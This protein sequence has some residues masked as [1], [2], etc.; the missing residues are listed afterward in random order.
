MD[1]KMEH[2]QQKTSWQPASEWY[3]SIVGEEGHYYHQAIIL[4]RLGRL[5]QIKGDPQASLLD[6]ACGQG[7][8]GRQVAADIDVYGFDIAPSLIK[9]ASQYDRSRRHHYA[10]AD[11]TKAL[12]LEKKDFSHAAIILALQ[13]IEHPQAA[14]SNA[15]KHLKPGGKLFLVLNHPHFRIPRQSSWKVDEGNKVQY[16]RVDRYMSP[17][18]IPIQTH[19]GKQ[20]Q[21]TTT[22][23]F[24]HPLASYSLW[25]KEAGFTME[26][27]EEWCSDK[28]STGKQAKMENR[29]REEIPLFMA[30]VARKGIL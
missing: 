13:N 16:R 11:V 9:A 21:S 20:E 14:L 18:K 26:L 27:I 4:P 17:M 3:N 19:P 5:M 29:S 7:I 1:G 24:H 22:F 15:S 2:K 6:L 8:L 25:L 30:I 28:V 23:S 12:P 10:V